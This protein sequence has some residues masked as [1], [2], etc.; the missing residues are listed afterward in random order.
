LTRDFLFR[1]TD[2]LSTD[3]KGQF[4]SLFGRV[5]PRTLERK[6]FERKYLRTPLGYSYHGLMMVDG[7]LVGAYNLI[8]YVYNFFGD[9]VMFGLSVD[10]MIG[11][12][13][14]GGPFSLLRMASLACSAAECDGISF[15]FGFPNDNAYEFTRRVLKWR[16][17]G[18]LDF[19]ALPIKIGAIEPRLRW[20]N[21]ISRVIAAGM[22]RVPPGRCPHSGF[23]IEKVHSERFE[24]HR[25]NHEHH[26]LRLE[27]GKCVYRT[28]LEGRVRTT[29][30][31]DVIPLTEACF[32]RA[33]QKVYDLAMG[34]TALLLYVGRLPFRAA[35]LVKLPPGKRPRQI[36]MCGRILDP[37]QIDDRIFDMGNWNVNISNFDVR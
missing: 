15:V 10:T 20:A 9:R 30:L 17:I 11:Q 13:H 18:T 25:Y 7:V 29:Y 22:V 32:T 37:R 21:F 14:R 3:E 6:E 26:V 35:G 28:C 27:G 2:E 31:I 1:R 5:F 12:E 36:H 8:P 33:V 4:L 19:H 23:G 16:D 24:G 34:Q